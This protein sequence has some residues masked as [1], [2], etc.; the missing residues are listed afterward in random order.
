MSMGDIAGVTLEVMETVGEEG[1][2]GFFSVGLGAEGQCRA[3]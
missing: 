3:I 1:V 2:D